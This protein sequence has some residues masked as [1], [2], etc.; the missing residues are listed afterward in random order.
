[1]TTTSCPGPKSMASISVLSPEQRR[2][3]GAAHC[4]FAE[5]DAAFPARGGVSITEIVDQ[6]AGQMNAQSAGPPLLDRRVNIDV[7]CS[8][9][10]PGLRVGVHQRD[11]DPAG[12]LAESQAN[13]RGR[14]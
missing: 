7:R 2:G 12:N 5:R 13:V 3:A 1:M 6:A 14:R 10:I 4:G 11:L 8:G 9:D